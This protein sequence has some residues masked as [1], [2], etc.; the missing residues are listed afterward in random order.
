VDYPF[1]NLGP[2][3][4]Q[5]FCQA[6]LAKRYPATQMFPVRQPD[7]GRDAIVYV[8]EGLSDFVMYQV[9]FVTKLAAREDPH[10][11]LLDVMQ[12]EAPKVKMQ[13]PKG[14]K[15]YVL[16]TNIA[17]TA[18][19]DVGSIDRMNALLSESL[20]VPSICLWRADLARDLDGLWD[21]KWVYPELMTGPDLIRAIVE[22]GLSE[23]QARRSSAIRAYVQRQSSLEAVV[24]FKQV[25]LQSNLLDLFVDVNA[26]AP[27]R[28]RESDQGTIYRHLLQEIAL[29]YLERRMISSP[30]DF[31]DGGLDMFG[32]DS[33]GVGAATLLLHARL[34]EVFPWAV[35]EG[36]PGQGKSTITQ[37]IGQVH[38]SRILGDAAT[39]RALPEHHR[40]MPVRLPMKLEL[41]DFATWLAKKNPFSAHSEPL[42]NAPYWSPSLESFL[43]AQV[44]HYSGGTHFV[45]DDL[46]AVCRLSAMLLLLDGLDEVADIAMRRDVVGEITA[47]VERLRANC[48]SLQVVVTSRPAAFA[49][50]PGLPE[51]KFAYFEMMSLNRPLTNEYAAKW[52]AA[53]GLDERVAADVTRTLA[54]KLEQ[55][56]LKDLAR[57][58]MQLV[59]LLSLIHT[60]GASLPDKRTA[61]YDSYVELFFNRESEKTPVVREWRDLLISIHRYVAWCIHSEVEKGQT[62]GAIEQEA[63]RQLV[64]AY[65]ARQGHDVR[66]VDELFSGVRERVAML[67]SRVQGTLEFEVQTLREYFAARYLYETAPYSPT[68]NER[69]GPKPARFAAIA[70]SFYWLNV[71]RFYAGCYS[72]GELAGLAQ[73]IEELA[74]R[75]GYELTSH[76]RALA[77]MLLAD[78]VFAQQPRTMES[79]LNFAL[80]GGHLK[81][82]LASSSHSVGQSSGI[83]LPAQCGRDALMDH[84]FE[85]LAS[86]VPTDYEDDIIALLRAN[87]GQPELFQRW[88][89]ALE[90]DTEHRRDWLDRAGDLGILANASWE[91]IAAAFGDEF[92]VGAIRILNRCGRLE[93]VYSTVE[94]YEVTLD[95]ILDDMVRVYA[96]FDSGEISVVQFV[97]L[98][99]A[100]GILA[101][102]FRG[103]QDGPLADKWS[104]EVGISS[105]LI[106]AIG[107]G[108][109]E[110][111]DVFV[112]NVLELSQR[113]TAEWA[114][115]IEL[116]DQV[117]ETARDCWGERLIT[118]ALANLAAGVRSGVEADEYRS[119]FDVGQSLARRAHY[120]RQR[121]ED[122]DWWRVQFAEAKS[123]FDRFFVGLLY[124]SWVSPET[125]GATAIEADEHVSNL[126]SDEQT[127]LLWAVRHARTDLRDE[128]GS[129]FDLDPRS[130]PETLSTDFIVMLAA[131]CDSELAEKLE[132]RYLRDYSGDDARVLRLKASAVMARARAGQESWE[133][134]ARYCSLLYAQGF[135]L[136]SAAYRRRSDAE[137]RMDPD[138]ARA[139]CAAPQD[140]PNFLIREAEG[141]CRESIGFESVADVA[142]REGWFVER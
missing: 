108:V 29:D 59:I 136:L 66:L 30:P 51:D 35:L 69:R 34:F 7:G 16:M 57:N 72:S 77:S 25:D 79:V 139:I 101:A 64:R 133:N 36:A 107:N 84:C 8:D 40:K 126:S 62:T 87:G 113:D 22:G 31:V 19:E 53:K 1:E 74:E 89:A 140:Y 137:A 105:A 78:W 65:L 41:R 4:F 60:R 20:G 125:L 142:E 71:T 128:S 129:Q 44:A 45:V 49:N 131:R 13:V 12:E 103:R 116:W 61:L 120:A 21:L 24:K 102:A 48:A 55:P 104:V 58:P 138:T 132:F 63:L 141:R 26:A 54:E 119:L 95:A 11:W 80:D 135:D 6:V 38:R 99:L 23:D 47:G 42:D 118:F 109:D 83:V 85:L 117:I 73:S 10:K 32:D 110:S 93:F 111:A 100:G 37:Y 56:H 5:E 112:S 124:F 46:L 68:G 86:G 106:P 15:A 3:R 43:A 122:A 28:L 94:K 70:R 130:L 92:G 97:G 81:L 9:K 91:E 115:R 27:R 114:N 88:R 18:H 14:A 76:P 90:Q 67:V 52:I 2:D 121:S 82:L 134:A 39:I 98:A 50:S 33:T 17:G 75:D 123:A 127:D 96:W